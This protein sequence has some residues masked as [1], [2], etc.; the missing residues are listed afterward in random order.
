M[1]VGMNKAWFSSST[2]NV[3]GAGYNYSLKGFK[4]TDAPSLNLGYL[5]DVQYNARVGYYL[6]YGL[7]ISLGIDHMKYMM[8]SPIEVLLNGRINPGIDN[9]T[10]LSGDYSNE[11]VTMD[12]LFS[13]NNTALNYINV[14][15]TKTNRIVGTRRNDHFLLSSDIGFAAGALVSKSNFTFGGDTDIGV[16]SLSGLGLNGYGALR[17]EFFEHVFL[18]TG[19]NFGVIRQIGVRLREGDPN[20]QLKQTIGFFEPEIMLGAAFKIKV[21]NDCSSCP[22]W[23]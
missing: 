7:N 17:F 15:F 6:R 16:T 18:Q 5:P 1:A 22:V 12:S 8:V 19:F 21:F 20:S 10:G 14:R 13:Y 3:L 23:K 4:A 11:G 2:L 9:E